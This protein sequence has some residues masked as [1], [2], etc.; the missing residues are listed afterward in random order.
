ME[1][2]RRRRFSQPSWASTL[3]VTPSLSVVTSGSPLIRPNH[4]WR[5]AARRRRASYIDDQLMAS[6]IMI[7]LPSSVTQRRSPSWKKRMG[8]D[9]GHVSPPPFIGPSPFTF[10]TQLEDRRLLSMTSSCTTVGFS[11]TCL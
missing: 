9:L 1:N 8:T 3:P 11:H 10:D 5:S 2:H 7:A 6:G 4:V